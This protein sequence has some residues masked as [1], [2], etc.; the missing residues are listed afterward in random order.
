MLLRNDDDVAGTR[1]GWLFAALIGAAAALIVL[2]GNPPNMGLCG[3]CFLRDVSGT[4]GFITAK[5]P[6]VFR[7][8]LVGLM[9]GAA[10]VSWRRNG[11]TARSGGHAGLRFFLGL[12]MGVAALVFLGCP[13][14]LMQR[15]GGGDLTALLPMPALVLGV[16]V[17]M[18]FERRGWSIGKTSP[19][20]RAVGLVAPVLA[21]GLLGCF[22]GGILLGPKTGDTF[23]PARAPWTAALGV[24]LV[25]G[26]L[27]STTGFCVISAARQVTGQKRGMLVAAAA[28]IAGYGAMLAA[29]GKWN[30]GMTGQF[31][32]HTDWAASAAA[33]FIL[34]WT[35]VLAGGCPIRQIIMTGEGNA[36]AFMGVAGI[37]I[38]T[39]I[40]HNFG[41]ASTPMAAGNPGGASVWALPW[42]GV[43]AAAC[44]LISLNGT[45]GKTSSA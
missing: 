24:S 11:F 32:A 17:G 10:L 27:L 26:I 44:L 33:L 19:A 41:V 13:F 43:A 35:G 39:C 18:Y 38:G 40:A 8:E 28:M 15:L 12:L 5:A 37:A 9:L 29:G 14:R 42:M 20:P 2:L 4:L 36:D 22:L 25:A 7:P 23:G 21:L 16:Q 6:W 31:G 45:S 1:R 3:A 34:G 30:P